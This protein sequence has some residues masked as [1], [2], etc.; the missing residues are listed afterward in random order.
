MITAKLDYDEARF[1][2]DL[3]D[4]YRR[5]RYIEDLPNDSGADETYDKLQTLIIDYHE[6]ER[7]SERPF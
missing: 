4:Q 2:L 3:I 7:F 5:K 1:L 6:D